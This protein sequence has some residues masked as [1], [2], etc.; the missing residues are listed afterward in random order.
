MNRRD[1]MRVSA[2]GAVTF[3]ARSYARILGAN[4]RVG[5]GIAGLGRRGTIVG[6]AFLEDDRTRLAHA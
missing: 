3:Q 1:F 5:L 2:T 6:D 4:D